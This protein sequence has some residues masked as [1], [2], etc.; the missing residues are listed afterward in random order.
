MYAK[1]QN[2]LNGQRLRQLA[3]IRNIV[4]YLFAI[5]VLAIAWSGVKTVQ[6]N[7]ELQKQIASLKQQNDVLGL[8]N[9]NIK[10]RSQYLQ[11]DQYLE[12]SARQN[13]GLAAPGEKVL[14]VPKATAMKF[15][16]PNLLPA[17]EPSEVNGPAQRPGYLKNLEDW[18]NFLLGRPLKSD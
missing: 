12:L 9:Q 14:L 2:L 1:L 5:I 18:R 13:F 11:T 6:S 16:K 17:A 8:Q 3:D 4:L 15:I 7:Y 10:L